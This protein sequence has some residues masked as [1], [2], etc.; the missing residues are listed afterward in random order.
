[1]NNYIKKNFNSIFFYSFAM[2][3]QLFLMYN[4]YYIILFTLGKISYLIKLK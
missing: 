1:M 3:Y 2:Y 4:I